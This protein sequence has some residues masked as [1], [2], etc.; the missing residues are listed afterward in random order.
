MKITPKKPS[1]QELAEKKRAAAQR[2]AKSRAKAQEA[3]L[4]RLRAELGLK[5]LAALAQIHP[6]PAK[7]VQ[8]LMG[9]HRDDNGRFLLPFHEVGCV[10]ESTAG[11]LDIQLP[12]E[13]AEALRRYQPFLTPGEVIEILIGHTLDPQ[14]P[15]DLEQLPGWYEWAPLRGTSP[16]GEPVKMMT[17]HQAYIRRCQRRWVQARAMG[18]PA[19]VWDSL[20]ETLDH[21]YNKAWSSF[22]RAKEWKNWRAIPKEPIRGADLRGAEAMAS[23]SDVQDVDDLVDNALA[24]AA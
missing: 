17:A 18:L 6:D 23:W 5:D 4:V 10:W 9:P 13:D 24:A 11:E 21:A 12:A 8:A 14:W 16:S 2:K 19:D 20:S 1:K 7:A 3:G 15:Q 22:G